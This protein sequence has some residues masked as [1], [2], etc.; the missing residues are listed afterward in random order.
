LK[1]TTQLLFTAIVFAVTFFITQVSFAAGFATGNNFQALSSRGQVT[2]SCKN[3][4]SP[5]TF[6]C[7]DSS[8]SPVEFDY[9]VGPTI[10]AD[11]V[12]LTV[13]RADQSER[14]KDSRYD[15]RRGVSVDRFNLWSASLFQRP[16]LA[17]GANRVHY[18]L[19]LKGSVVLEGDF[20]ATVTRQPTA[21][22]QDQSYNSDDSSD[23]SNQYAI[24]GRYFEQLH[25]CH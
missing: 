6:D 10:N 9:F 5:A 21:V 25:Y 4:S 2:V 20:T 15:F 18:A 1:P 11:T 8:L 24:C 12:I 17:D 3:V 14:T 23:C 16:L 13:T 7:W 19:T 22:C